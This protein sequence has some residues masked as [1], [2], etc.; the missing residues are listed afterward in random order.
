[1]KGAAKR[2]AQVDTPRGRNS[3]GLRSGAALAIESMR[4]QS[5]RRFVAFVTRIFSYGNTVT[6]RSGLPGALPGDQ[7]RFALCVKR[8]LGARDQAAGGQDVLRS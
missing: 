7:G 1:M 6:I 4:A 5:L 3:C 8:L 2:A